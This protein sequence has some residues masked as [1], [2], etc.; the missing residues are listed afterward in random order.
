MELVVIVVVVA[1]LEYIYISLQVGQGRGKYEVPAPAISGHPTFERLYRV[2]MNTLEQLIVFLPAIGLFATY[3]SAGIAAALG[4]VFIVGRFLYL[5][6]YVED[7]EKRT[8]GFLLG[9]VANAILL[10]G[11]LI[12]AAIKLL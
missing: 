1:L 11:A 9:F 7:P 6:G 8:V 10:L 4:V 3:V 5:R 2:Q 12:G